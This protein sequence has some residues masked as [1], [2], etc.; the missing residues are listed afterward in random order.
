MAVIH[1]T[2][3]HFSISLCDESPIMIE[4]QAPKRNL[5]TS[6]TV[7][8]RPSRPVADSLSSGELPLQRLTSQ[9]TLLSG[10]KSRRPSHAYPHV[11]LKPAGMNE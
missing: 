2:D 10:N 6:S 5:S 9:S 7:W 8:K 4:R 1:C 11:P 3:T